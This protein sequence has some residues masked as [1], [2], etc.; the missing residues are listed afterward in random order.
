M[1]TPK[2]AQSTSR[3]Y[4]VSSL[5]TISM[6][7]DVVAE[8]KSEAIEIASSR[9]LQGLCHQCSSGNNALEN[10]EWVTSGELDGEPFDLEVTENKY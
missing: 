1:K 3:I 7:T 9:G 4:R 10:E 8:S 5:V 2:N 6:Y